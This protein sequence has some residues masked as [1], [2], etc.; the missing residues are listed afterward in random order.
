MPK[1]KTKKSKKTQKKK[2][3]Q[4]KVSK[5]KRASAKKPLKTVK[6]SV[7]KKA[8]KKT[9]KAPK[10]K[11]KVSWGELSARE[12]AAFLADYLADHEVN[13]MLTGSTCAACYV[14]SITPKSVDLVTPIYHVEKM[15]K[16]MKK[17]GLKSNELRTFFH[18]KA[19]FDI[20][21]LPPPVTS[22]DSRVEELVV[23]ETIYGQMN[24][25][26]ITDCVMQRL[27]QWY[28]WGELDAFEEALLL[29]KNYKV[30][31]AQIKLWSSREWAT[32][33][34]TEFMKALKTI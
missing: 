26:G 6:K 17:V 10:K 3:L 15:T 8:K 12:A 33:K 7:K 31:F 13:T 29:A 34:F 5:K 32:E 27:A 28:H 11:Y 24:I 30:D 20:H 9:K 25:L 1:K 14:N 2:K 4:K 19:P 22:G 16:L 21:F 18:S 23:Q